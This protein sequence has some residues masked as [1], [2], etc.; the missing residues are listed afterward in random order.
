METK[1]INMNQ[2]QVNSKYTWAKKAF[3]DLLGPAHSASPRK[4][5]RWMWEHSGSIVEVEIRYNCGSF[6]TWTVYVCKSKQEGLIDFERFR[7]YEL[8]VRLGYNGVKHIFSA[9][10]EYMTWATNNDQY[11]NLKALCEQG[12]YELA[13]M[14]AKTNELL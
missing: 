10:F 12:D 3:T 4:Y 9:L 7:W 2:L 11:Q 1:P 8:S 14:L 6:N 13:I 5:T